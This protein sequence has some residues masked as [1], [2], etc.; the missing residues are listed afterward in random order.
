MRSIAVKDIQQIANNHPE[1]TIVVTCRN[2]FYNDDLDY[3]ECFFLNSFT[4]EDI[5]EYVEFKGVDHELFF[6]FLEKNKLIDYSTNPFFFK[7]L[8]SFMMQIKIVLM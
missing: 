3:F 7:Q 2:N 1:I 6:A 4:M 5:R 8:S